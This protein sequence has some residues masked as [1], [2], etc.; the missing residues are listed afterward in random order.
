M[1]PDEKVLFWPR[2]NMSEFAAHPM[3]TA[4]ERG[5][6]RPSIAIPN[7]EGEF[8][9]TGETVVTNRRVW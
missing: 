5:A 2:M 6:H 4:K 3:D 1:S 8:F 7:N 9:A